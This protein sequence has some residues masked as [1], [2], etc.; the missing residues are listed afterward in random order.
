MEA[1][2]VRNAPTPP[3]GPTG[4][5]LPPCSTRTPQGSAGLRALLPAGIKV[6]S[7]DPS[8]LLNNHLGVKKS[9][10]RSL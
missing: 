9:T 10:P 6:V 3:A 4:T 8:C 1:E 2:A 7:T 5:Q